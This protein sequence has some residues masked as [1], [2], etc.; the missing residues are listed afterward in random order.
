MRHVEKNIICYVMHNS[1][2]TSIKGEP[3]SSMFCSLSHNI[4]INTLENT[5]H[6]EANVWETQK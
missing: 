4:I 5:K 3:K 6:L 2:T 1:D